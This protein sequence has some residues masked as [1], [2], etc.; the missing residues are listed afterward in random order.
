[1]PRPINNLPIDTRD[2][3]EGIDRKQLQ[4]LKQ[5][6]LNINQI[7]FERSCQALTERQQDFLRLIPL[8]FHVNHPLLPG[9]ISNQV[10]AGVLHY[11]PQKDELQLA[12]AFA[13]SFHYQKELSVKQIYIDAIF[14]MG[15]PGSIAQND[16]SD[17][18]LW[19]CYK[20]GLT[21][22]QREKL[23]AKADKIADWAFKTIHLKVHAFLMQ[24]DAFKN[25]KEL[26]FN[27]EAS[28]SAQYYLLLDEFYRTALWLAGKVPL[29]WFVPGEREA[30]YDNYV[31]ILLEKRFIKSSD[32]ID[33]GGIAKIPAEEFLGAGIWQ[34]Y[35]AIESPYKSVLKLLLLEVYATQK[36]SGMARPLAVDFKLAIYQGNSDANQLDPY[37]LIYQRIE[38]Y[39]LLDDSRVRLELA[40]RC[41]YFKVNR[42]LSRE[43]KSSWQTELLQSLVD[44]WGWDK[45]KLQQLDHRSN[46]KAPQVMEEH[47]LLV[48]ELSHSYQLLTDLHKRLQLSALIRQDELRVLGRKLYA[49][50]ERRAGKVNLI[51]PGISS[52][53]QETELFFVQHKQADALSWSVYTDEK[54]SRVADI[55]SAIKHA[56]HLVELVFW[57]QLN[58]LI[59]Q[60][61]RLHFYGRHFQ[62]SFSQHQLLSSI[63]QWLPDTQTDDHQAF[64]SPADVQHILFIVNL[65]HEPQAELLKKGLHLISN[66]HDALGYSGLRENLVQSLDMVS[67]NSWGEVV[68]RHFEKDALVQSIVF[69][70]Q[71]VNKQGFK[72]PSIQFNC[73]NTGKGNLIA[74]R[75]DIL[76]KQ[77]HACF[78]GYK[79]NQPRFVME[80]G[81]DI[82][83]LESPNTS[84]SPVFR[85]QSVAALI[86]KLSAPLKQASPVIIDAYA[87]RQTPLAIIYQAYNPQAVQIFYYL[88]P[89]QLQVYLLDNKG[90][91][92]QHSIDYSTSSQF[93]RHVYLFLQNLINKLHF[94]TSNPDNLPQVICHELLHKNT[95]SQSNLTDWQ[96]E[97]RRIET[98]LT[99]AAPFRIKV[100][101][102]YDEDNREQYLIYSNQQE[103]SS[104]ILGENIFEQV[105]RYIK[106]QRKS[107][108]FYPCYITD[109]DISFHKPGEGLELMEFWKMK[110]ALEEKI[111]LAFTGSSS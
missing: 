12:K 16:V 80:I 82:I 56:P 23:Q 13:R 65:G 10:P 96:L 41:F 98:D 75:L 111:N 31:A 74:Q 103:F 24:S 38:D 53:L 54:S 59:N 55:S 97:P 87:L 108:D 32:V 102:E 43:K 110:I 50:F 35:K 6:F 72:L 3:E 77:L 64:H 83:L 25:E 63:H 49:A 71:T 22:E 30:D 100:I 99:R 2:I 105:A 86:K 69:Y 78:F 26:A 85:C 7:R 21:D 46:W 14:V 15:S 19:I 34:L 61:S 60:G 91:L 88:Q 73:F 58:G 90:S 51:N 36:T 109:L 39:L 94:D 101:V 81:E 89:Q 107:Q 4:L 18:D 37:L 17:L 70:L 42:P 66:Q 93:L 68:C 8:L 57:C 48:T 45:Y 76:W 29:W 44:H 33:F 27:S 67:I 84:Q 1:M 106:S 20:P 40:R 62:Q 104:Y 79:Q 52:N 5:R 9:Y 47:S 28:G 11:Q 95:L 92:M